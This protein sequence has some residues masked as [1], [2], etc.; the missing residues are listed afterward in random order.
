M[1][2]PLI[3]D[4]GSLG[5]E[6]PVLGPWFST[7]LTLPAPDDNLAVS[8]AV[9]AGTDWL[10]PATGLL[11]FQVAAAAPPPLLAGLRGP[12]GTPPFT[13][14]RLIAVFR[15]LPEVGERLAALLS[16]IPPA[17]GTAVTPRLVTRAAVRTFALE[18]PEDPPTLVT[19]DGRVNPSIPPLSSDSERAAVVGLGHTGGTLENSGEPMTDLKRPG[20][21]LGANEKLLVFPAATT[22]RLYTFDGRGRAID[23]GAVAAW[24]TRLTTTFDNLFAAGATRTATVDPQLTVQLVGTRR[25]PR[26]DGGSHP[27]DHRQRHRQFCGQSPGSGSSRRGLHPDRRDRRRRTAPPDRRTSRWNL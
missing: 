20:Q 24:W 3:P 27:A 18:L 7:D 8:V 6:S 10:P 25:R 4:P 26:H 17:D 23:P 12:A 16:D 1:T 5:L 19:L 22:V 14:G 9:P 21:F 15:L 11:S 13:T 2:T